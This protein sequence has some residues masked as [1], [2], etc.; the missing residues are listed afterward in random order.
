MG[1]RVKKL[2]YL[3]RSWKIQYQSRVNGR[4][5]RDIPE[6]QYLSLGF[7]SS[8]SF[9]EAKARCQQLNAMEHLKRI[10]EKRNVIE[11]RLKEEDIKVNSLLPQLFL[12]EFE[13]LYIHEEKQVI[14]WRT[15]KKLLVDLNIPIEDWSFK[16]EL[17][18][19]RFEDDAYSYSYVQKLIHILNRWGKFISYKQKSYFEP[20]PL[21]RNREKERIIDT[22]LDEKGCQASDPL[23]PEQL[24]SKKDCFSIEHYNW[25]FISVWLGLRPIEIDRLLKP[26][27]KT[28]WYL[29]NNILWVYQSKLSGIARDKRL[30]PI[31][32]KYPEQLRVI[33]LLTS[34]TFKR[35]LNKT[36]QRYFT[37]R[38]TCYAG[39]KG[40]TDLM[41]QLGNSLEAIS[42]WLGHKNIDRT[43]KSYKDKNK[44]L[45]E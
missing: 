19:R 45:L 15:A 5:D 12:I 13:K 44:V 23:T 43:W 8:M 21:P 27:S 42:M 32:L 28:T 24:E 37:E 41:L 40:F 38:T 6:G 16:K 10:Q 25:L 29:D 20:I 34:K 31:P 9:D 3:K 11:E 2:P 17:F 1:Y 33:P 35:P 14:H 22:F 36:L 7:S 39:R 30:K 4:K 26:S 18:Y